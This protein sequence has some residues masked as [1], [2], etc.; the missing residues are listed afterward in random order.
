LQLEE[1]QIPYKVEKIPMRCYGEKPKSFFDLNP[2][3]GIPVAIVKGKVISESKY[4]FY[5]L[6]TI[7]MKLKNDFIIFSSIVA[8]IL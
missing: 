1:K 6:I 7:I 3:G 2:S 4:I 5:N 8:V